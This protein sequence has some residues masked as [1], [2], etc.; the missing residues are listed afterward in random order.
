[1]TF[2]PDCQQNEP[3]PQRDVYNE[4]GTLAEQV[5]LQGLGP[6]I[7]QLG[8][9]VHADDQFGTELQLGRRGL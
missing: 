2:A 7:N 5:F 3:R 4:S 1:M 6:V 8:H 9:L